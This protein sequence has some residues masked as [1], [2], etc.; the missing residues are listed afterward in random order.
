[1]QFLP[2]QPLICRK[3]MQKVRLRKDCLQK[4]LVFSPVPSPPAEPRDWKGMDFKRVSCLRN[5]PPASSCQHVHIA[6][7]VYKTVNRH[8]HILWFCR[9]WLGGKG[10]KKKGVKLSSLVSFQLESS[11]SYLIYNLATVWLS[12]RVAGPN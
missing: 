6:F 9:E 3:G 4:S 1:M 7:D 12:D 11:L 8:L 5:I 10:K 2:L